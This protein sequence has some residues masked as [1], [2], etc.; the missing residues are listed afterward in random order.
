MRPNCFPDQI[1]HPL[2]TRCSVCQEVET[3]EREREREKKRKRE[4]KSK[5]IEMENG[6]RDY[7]TR[8]DSR[9]PE[10]D[11]ICYGRKMTKLI[12][13]VGF[14]GRRIRKGWERGNHRLYSNY[15]WAGNFGAFFVA[16]SIRNSTTF[17][18]ESKIKSRIRSVLRA[19]SKI[20]TALA[21]NLSC[22]PNI[23]KFERNLVRS[24]AFRAWAGIKRTRKR[25]DLSLSLSLSV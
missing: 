12:S 20:E 16:R 6:I 3:R 15:I 7:V 1:L 19:N 13:S 23:I 4:K 24:F 9:E 22:N 21:V 10:I 8:A 2:D 11:W 5:A 17:V 14:A 25:E 18:V